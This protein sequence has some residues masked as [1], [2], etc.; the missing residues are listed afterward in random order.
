MKLL[1]AAQKIFRKALTQSDPYACVLKNLELK[2]N[3]LVLKAKNRRFPLSAF[4]RILVLGA[5][6]AS[7]AM[8]QGLE[9]LLKKS[10]LPY[11]GILS[12]KYGHGKP[13]TGITLIEAGHPLPDDNGIR[14]AEQILALC[15]QAAKDDLVIALISGGGS[16]LLASPVQRISLTDKIT[17]T[18][19]LL[20]C[21]AS[22]QEINAVRKHISKVKGG[23]LAKAAAPAAVINL[24]LSDVLYDRMDVI[25][26]GPF[27][28][29][30][31]TYRD[32]LAVLRKYDIEKQVPQAVMTYLKAG[33]AARI[34][35]TA[36]QRD[37]VF[38]RVFSSII[39]SNSLLLE[40]AKQ[41]AEK[42]GFHTL[43]LS[44]F[45]Q[46]EARELGSFLAS[47]AH[48]IKT[49][50][51]P[52]S[53]PACI[54]MGGETT[55]TLHGNGKGGRSQE[56]AL[57]AARHIAGLSDTLVYCA[58]SDGTD[59]P[60]DAAGAWCSGKTLAQ[61]EKM[62]VNADDHLKRNDSYH[63]FEKLSGLIKTG[64]TG[65][66]LLDLYLLLVGQG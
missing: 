55:V 37:P 7:A 21:G 51:R 47:M 56:C 60:T 12:V 30:Q 46:G 52:V 62:G 34:P 58:G 64:P 48:E 32:A 18:K 33:A 35:E 53:P 63:Y 57:Q 31:S 54:L 49:T 29:D 4:K 45:V 14:A 1:K 38:K 15:N 22:I 44:S 19:K 61:G 13:L 10:T 25:A 42:L 8:A 65:T 20:A 6:K 17:T 50:G 59:G 36:K 40:A 43:L 23:G 2:D 16:S 27:V 41:E 28:P 24:L 39:G 66:N 5:G 9:E 26:S 3:A 11:Q